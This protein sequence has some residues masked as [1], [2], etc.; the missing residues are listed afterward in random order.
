L[1]RQPPAAGLRPDDEFNQLASR[2]SLA[3]DDYF[4]VRRVSHAPDGIM[5]RG[6]TDY[7][8]NGGIAFDDLQIGDQ[9]LFATNP[10]L[11]ALGAS[12]WDYPTVLITDIDTTAEKQSLNLTRL[13]V[14]GFGA[15]DLDYPSFQLLLMRTV[16]AALQGIQNFI[17]F[18]IAR[19]KARADANHQTFTPPDKLNWDGGSLTPSDLQGN[20]QAI[21]RRWSSA[22]DRELRRRIGDLVLRAREIVPVGY[23]QVGELPDLNASLAAL[24]SQAPCR[25]RPMAPRWL[26]PQPWSR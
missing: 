2:F 18:E 13:R 7:F 21:V 4:E 11:T 10:V 15:A 26:R 22:D 23:D 16:D 20:D 9:V 17:P 14:Q 8:E 24:L 25:R 19:Q 6:R 1:L 3:L 5:R 12:A